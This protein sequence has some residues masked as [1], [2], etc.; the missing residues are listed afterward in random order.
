MAESPF[1]R[2]KVVFKKEQ[3]LWEKSVERTLT[4]IDEVFVKAIPSDDVKQLPPRYLYPVGGII[5]IVLAGIFI[6]VFLPGTYESCFLFLSVNSSIV[7]V[8]S[9]HFTYRLLFSN[10]DTILGT[11]KQRE[12]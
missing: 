4:K 7:S 1:L 12:L 10:Q 3:S 8:V 6:A 2:K 11:T 5:F 9:C